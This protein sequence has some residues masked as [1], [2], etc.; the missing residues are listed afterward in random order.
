[1]VKTNDMEHKPIFRKEAKRKYDEKVCTAERVDIGNSNNHYKLCYRSK[2]GDRDN[3]K[4]RQRKFRHTR[5]GCKG[6]NKQVCS[7]CWK[8]SNH[9]P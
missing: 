4:D 9:K 2:I 5:L 1:M 7:I 8:S 3:P 6:Y